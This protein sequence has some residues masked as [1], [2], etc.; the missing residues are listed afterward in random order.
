MKRDLTLNDPSNIKRFI[1]LELGKLDKEAS[2]PH[3]PIGRL[4]DWGRL[5]WKLR[6]IPPTVQT[7]LDLGITTKIRLDLLYGWDE[8][9]KQRSTRSPCESSSR[10]DL[11][12]KNS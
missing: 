8:R 9:K 10:P 11:K 3:R 6:G 12:K 7:E 2:I 4:D 1:Y 5:D